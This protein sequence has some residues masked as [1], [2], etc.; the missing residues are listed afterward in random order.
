MYDNRY[1]LHY[2]YKHKYE[3]LKYTN[4][5]LIALETLS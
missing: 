1:V 4:R 3:I 5:Y 2:K